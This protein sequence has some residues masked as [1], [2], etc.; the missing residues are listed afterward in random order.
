MIYLS[1]FFLRTEIPIKV[2]T[3][4]KKKTG[5]RNSRRW[6]DASFHLMTY[7]SFRLSSKKCTQLFLFLSQRGSPQRMHEG[8]SYK[9]PSRKKKAHKMAKRVYFDYNAT[10]PVCEAAVQEMVVAA[11]D[12]WGNPSSGHWAG[13]RAK[14]SNDASRAR[15]ASA[16]GCTPEE[17]L[18]T[19]GGT[20]SN[21]LAIFGSLEVLSET[22]PHA[23]H[24]ITTNIE[25]PAVL[26]VTK[27]LEKRGYDVTYLPTGKDGSIT[28]DQIAAAITEKSVL[29]TVM[30]A[31]NETGVV[32]P[33]R[34]IAD[35]ASSKGVLFHTDA[36][37]SVGKVDTS[38]TTLGADLLTICSHK[39]YGPKGVGALYIKKGHIIKNQVFGA[40]HESGLRPGT[41]STV[42]NAGM[43]VALSEAV[44][45]L[46]QRGETMRAM[47]D[48]LLAQLQMHFEVEVNGDIEKA[49]PNTLNCSLKKSGG[50][51]VSSA[52]IIAGV[53]DVVALSAGSACHS[54][55][56]KMSYVHEALGLSRERAGAALRLR[57]DRFFCIL[58]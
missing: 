29:I 8:I 12:D 14:A 20:E 11:S 43:S 25:H 56:A 37:Q 38:V 58:L 10:T 3:D 36:S 42:L 40:G 54:G 50:G 9:I 52:A 13:H 18:F 4:Q 21:N 19:S 16:M 45:G 30:H 7:F 2:F 51:Y 41:E 55:D 6:T 27:Q 44:A 57:Y 17:I 39:F 34:A 23:K 35:V 28:S 5:K 48:L 31:N 26:N 49:L 47:R 1:N 32:Q 53:Q 15:I 46:T 24:I 22:H 33:I